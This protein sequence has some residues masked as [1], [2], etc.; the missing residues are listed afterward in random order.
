MN[1][2]L[3]L[4]PFSILFLAV[5]LIEILCDIL[6]DTRWGVYITKPLLM[7]LLMIWAKLV[8]NRQDKVMKLL[9]ISLF[10]SFW[11]DFFLMFNKEEFFIFGLASFLIAHILYIWLFVV[12]IA[13]GNPV[14]MNQKILR[15]LPFAIFYILFMAICI[16]HIIQVDA[17]MVGPVLVYA[18]T[19]TIMGYAASL[20]SRAVNPTSFAWVLIGAIAFVLSD[21]CIAINKFINPIPYTAIPVMTLYGIGQLLITA[22]ILQKNT[23]LEN[24]N[25]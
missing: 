8:S 24:F 13:A 22:G 1:K 19:I 20:R 7:P 14:V 23:K 21:T 16:P 6:L 25:S 10:F 4:K 9:Y 15:V 12:E 11:G 17:A 2:F 18:L 5:L 3:T